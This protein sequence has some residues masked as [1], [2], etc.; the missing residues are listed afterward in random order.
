M[1][2]KETRQITKP[3]YYDDD[4]VIHACDSAIMDRYVRLVWT[5]CD[6]HVPDDP[7]FTVKSEAPA[8]T[9]CGDGAAL[10]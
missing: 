7:G 2:D 10:S 1:S 9:G 4:E 3:I 6:R 5:K 8:M